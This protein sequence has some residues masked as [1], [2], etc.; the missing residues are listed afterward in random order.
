MKG[1]VAWWPEA[2]RTVL[3][4]DWERGSSD[5][6]WIHQGLGPVRLSIQDLLAFAGW[7]MGKEEAKEMSCVRF[8]GRLYPSLYLPWKHVH[9]MHGINY[10]WWHEL[11]MFL[12]LFQNEKRNQ[13]QQKLKGWGL[14]VCFYLKS[15]MEKRCKLLFFTYPILF[16]YVQCTVYVC[17]YLT[18]T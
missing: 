7:E 13:L 9:S 4:I 14:F 8:I 1:T 16:T 18:W 17:N 12:N 5:L 15:T 3:Q 11:F 10:I 6:G 2:F